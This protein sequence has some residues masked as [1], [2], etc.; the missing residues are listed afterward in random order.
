VRPTSWITG[1][2]A[3][4]GSSV[5]R[6]EG[7]FASFLEPDPRWKVKSFDFDRD[8]KALDDSPAALANATNPD[9]A[10]FK[11]RGGKMILYHGW[12]DA[13]VPPLSTVNYD[14][15]VV[16]KMGQ[17]AADF[18]RLYMVP[19]MQHCGGG[20]GPNSFREKM[21]TALEAMGGRWCG[22]QHRHRLE[23]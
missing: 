9:L 1:S 6:A 18:S 7:F 17:R 21:T 19:G 16:S 11:D 10:A 15:Q 12:S 5:V 13:T 8:A 22:S 4:Q 23:I 14:N 3:R 20:P 2:G